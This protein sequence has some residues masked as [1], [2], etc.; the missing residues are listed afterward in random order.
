M[1]S[2]VMV[3]DNKPIAFRTNRYGH[4]YPLYSGVPDEAPGPRRGR[5]SFDG[6]YARSDKFPPALMG[7]MGERWCKREN[8]KVWG[9]ELRGGVLLLES[10]GWEWRRHACECGPVSDFGFDWLFKE[11]MAVVGA[12]KSRLKPVLAV[13]AAS[14]GTGGA[15]APQFVA[16][17]EVT[18][19][20]QRRCLRVQLS[21]VLEAGRVVRGSRIE[22]GT[23]MAL[24]IDDSIRWCCSVNTFAFDCLDEK[25]SPA[26]LEIPPEWI[27]GSF[28]LI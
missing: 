18:E 13:V 2:A 21:G 4:R 25:A 26:E 24:G 14:R 17:V 23:L 8:R 12:A 16:L 7:G 15:G 20:M 28:E 5:R 3:V 9:V 6:I 22:A 11:A 19:A 10:M 27:P 1:G